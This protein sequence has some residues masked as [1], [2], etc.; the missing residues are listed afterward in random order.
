MQSFAPVNT[1][2]AAGE[3]AGESPARPYQTL[4]YSVVAPL[5]Q[6]FS[7]GLLL[8]QMTTRRLWRSDPA[9]R[10][11]SLSLTSLLSPQMSLE[12]SRLGQTPV[13]AELSTAHHQKCRTFVPHPGRY[14]YISG[15]SSF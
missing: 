9:N 11:S 13:A 6:C 8:M 14:D 5:E 4:Q 1:L 2:A 12:L 7:E 3:A 15:N 10:D